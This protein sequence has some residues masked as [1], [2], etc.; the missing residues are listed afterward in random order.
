M[1]EQPRKKTL[2]EKIL[3]EKMAAD[4]EKQDPDG[5]KRKLFGAGLLGTI[6]LALVTT[7]LMTLLTFGGVSTCTFASCTHSFS[8]SPLVTTSRRHSC[9]R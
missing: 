3:G 2:K 5:R 1:A 8:H 4:L 7:F 6:V 9:S